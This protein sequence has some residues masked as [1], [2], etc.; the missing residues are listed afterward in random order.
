MAEVVGIVAGVGSILKVL[1][2]TSIYLQGIGNA[3]REAQEVAN[4]VH[5]TEAIL[6]SLK[7]SLKI[8]HRSQEFYGVWGDSTKLVLQNVKT[9][10][11]ELNKRLGSQG[12]KAKLNFW[13]K[14]KWPLAR[15]E[16]LRLQQ[17]MQAYM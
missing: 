6:K 14:A 3:S 1:T 9:T 7:A 5:A 12:G 13:S 15:E 16:G 4:Q 11:E 2:S 8:V 10:T 17:H